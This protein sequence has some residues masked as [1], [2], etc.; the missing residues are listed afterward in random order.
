MARGLC[1]ATR[2]YD[3][4]TSQ[5]RNLRLQPKLQPARIHMPNAVTKCTLRPGGAG[6]TRTH[7]RRIMSPASRAVLAASLTWQNVP[8]TLTATYDLAAYLPRS[9]AQSVCT[10]ADPCT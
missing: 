8:D 4:P 1:R 7:D 6:G 10:G 5:E 2:R 9:S 3:K